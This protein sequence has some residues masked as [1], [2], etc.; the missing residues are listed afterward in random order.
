MLQKVHDISTAVKP[1]RILRAV[2]VQTPTVRI[3]DE[4]AAV[5]RNLD[6]PAPTIWRLKINQSY[7]ISNGEWFSGLLRIAE[8]KSKDEA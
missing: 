4:I 6:W 3:H 2:Q 8:R 5:G 7:V 1:E